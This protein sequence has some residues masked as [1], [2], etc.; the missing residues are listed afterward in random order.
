M[1]PQLPAE[2]L[3]DCRPAKR[4]RGKTLLVFIWLCVIFLCPICRSIQ[5]QI[6]C[7]SRTKLTQPPCLEALT[8]LFFTGI[9]FEQPKN[10]V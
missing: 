3:D 8:E 2:A 1:F 6:I 10:F 5:G 7:S 4:L 9:F